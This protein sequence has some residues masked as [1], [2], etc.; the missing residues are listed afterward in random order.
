MIDADCTFDSMSQLKL[1]F[2]KFFPFSLITI[3]LRR[4]I[5][6][7]GIWVVLMLTVTGNIFTRFGVEY[8]FLTPEY[9][10]EVGPFSFFLLGVFSGLFVMAFHISTYIF[11]SLRFPFLATL[12][13]PFYSFAINNS[14]LPVVFY[15]IY[16]FNIALFLDSDGYSIF[17][18]FS[19]ISMLLLGVIFIIAIIFS[20]FFSTLKSISPPV[21]FKKRQNTLASFFGKFDEKYLSD[22]NHERVYAYLKSPFKIRLARSARH[23]SNDLL[24]QTIHSHHFSAV[25]FLM[26]LIFLILF[27]G[28][29]STQR[30]LVL[31][32]AA[33][34][35]LLLSLGLLLYSLLYSWFKSWN[36]VFLISA[37]FILNQFH[38]LRSFHPAFG[39]DYNREAVEYSEK[40]LLSINRQE[41]ID[42][43]IEQMEAVLNKWKERTGEARPSLM[44]LNA[45]GGGLRSAVFTYEL[46]KQLDSLSNGSF[47]RHCF[48]VSGASGGM[49][50]ATYYQHAYGNRWE[51]DTNRNDR[52]QLGR[53][54]IAKDL[55]NPTMFQFALSDVFI[56]W[57]K[58]E[59][60]GRKY[61]MDRGYSFDQKLLTNTN[62]LLSGNLFDREQREQSAELPITL[63]SPTL[64][65]DGRR[66][67]MCASPIS[68]LGSSLQYPSKVEELDGVE[69]GRMFENHGARNVP[70]VT[71]LRMSATFP[72]ITP[73]V[74]L[75][76]NPVL[77]IIDAGVRDNDGFEISIRFLDKLTP[78]IEKNCSS[79]LILRFRGD[80]PEGVAVE[81]NDAG[82]FGQWLRPVDGVVKSFSNFQTFSKVEL[83]NRVKECFPIQPVFKDYYLLTKRDEVSLSWHLTREEKSHI[84]NEVR[85]IGIHSAELDFLSQ[86]H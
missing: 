66:L 9:L 54:N 63:L 30:V 14:L 4:N 31:P 36:L 25:L 41:I 7:I 52:L 6:L 11:H 2:S 50:G 77:D 47:S 20:Y 32:A 64:V 5:P 15:L 29:F 53:D 60:G 43:D 83:K 45:S 19:Y 81:P 82:V 62:H 27:L 18:I 68:F 24:F 61:T 26:G 70:L 28:Y 74:Q 34:G 40:T 21:I 37:F 86:L 48:L 71:A 17:Q 35:F 57:R 8:L 3:M 38:F 44:L 10:D 1:L 78:W 84:I 65:N 46:C 73:L 33:S 76:S 59:V 13:R 80:R 23:Y 42:A 75:P 85:K 22:L 16:T 69:F 56:R 72:Y 55:L 51:E 58:V 12:H 39:M 67:M 49:L 79:V